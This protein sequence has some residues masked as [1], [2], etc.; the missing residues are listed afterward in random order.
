MLDF[1]NLN[2][3][4]SFFDKEI[5]DTKGTKLSSDDLKEYFNNKNSNKAITQKSSVL[6][7]LDGLL[8]TEISIPKKVTFQ[9]IFNIFSDNKR[10]S[11]YSYSTTPTNYDKYFY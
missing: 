4:P 5:V 2:Y 3:F 11:I 1:N 6:R 9:E 10:A 8:H 7:N